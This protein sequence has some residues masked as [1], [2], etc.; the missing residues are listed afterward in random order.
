VREHGWLRN[1]RSIS[2]F[3]G[4]GGVTVGRVQALTN[5]QLLLEPNNDGNEA[6]DVFVLNSPVRGVFLGDRVRVSYQKNNGKKVALRIEELSS[7][8]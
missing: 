1:L 3:K 8:Q 4:S 5:D 2:D 7:R 6:A